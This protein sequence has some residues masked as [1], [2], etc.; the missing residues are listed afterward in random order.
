[1]RRV[2]SPAPLALATDVDGDGPPVVLL[3]GITED[4]TFWAPLVAPLATSATVVRVDLR[5]HGES[6]LGPGYELADMADDV[7]AALDA[8]G[9]T[10]PPLVV[11]HSLGGL[12]AAVYAGRHPVRGVVDVDQP[13]ALTAM[14]AQVQQ[15]APMLRG[16]G[17]EPFMAGM[18]DAMR[19]AM[20]D[21]AHAAL[22][23]RR[24]PRQEVVTGIW[25]PLLDLTGEEL[26]ALVDEIA[27]GVQC[28]FLSLHGLDPGPDYA[29]WLAQRIPTATVEVW[30]DDAG[31]PLGHHPHLMAPERFMARVREFS[32]GLA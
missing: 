18:F 4:R 23:A 10:E 17:F 7:R 26:G 21:D 1:M 3:H 30:T 12:L 22:A 5:G 32:A 11:G 19:G 20:D 15:A 9:V 16:E 14:Q 2:T 31:R 28:P 29:A 24:R 27:A 25:S 13:L 6:P 8:A